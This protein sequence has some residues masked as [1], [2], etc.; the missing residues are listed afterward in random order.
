MVTIE[1]NK[2]DVCCCGGDKMIKNTLKTIEF[3][4]F[5]NS[6]YVKAMIAL[7]NLDKRWSQLTSLWINFLEK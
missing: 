3:L 7:S 1:N 5:K 2:I 6:A 4:K